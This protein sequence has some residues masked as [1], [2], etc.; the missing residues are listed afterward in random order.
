MRRILDPLFDRKI[1]AAICLATL[2]SVMTYLVFFAI[3]MPPDSAPD[4]AEVVS[5]ASDLVIIETPYQ[6]GFRK[7]YDAF[8][9]QID[10]YIPQP[11]VSAT[12]IASYSVDDDGVAEG[13]VDGYHRATALEYCPAGSP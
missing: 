10:R 13:Y 5:D 11:S 8:L 3:G 2:T 1:F 12:R 4:S 9:K 6:Y 7:G